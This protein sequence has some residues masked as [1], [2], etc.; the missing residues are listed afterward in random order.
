MV[1]TKRAIVEIAE[2]LIRTKGYHA[3]SYADISTP[4]KIKNSA[5]HYHFPSKEDLGIAVIEK[6]KERFD[7]LLN[8][9]IK[10][11]PTFLLTNFIKVYTQSQK[12]GMICFMGALGPAY[13]SL[14]IRM[15][16][17]LR[18]VANEIRNW[19][20]KLLERGRQSNDFHFE[21]RIEEKADIIISSLMSSLILNEVI[22]KDITKNV[23]SAIMSSIEK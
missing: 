14:P 23:I 20:I 21:E 9:G 3:F 17:H 8:E 10:K 18:A 15:Q 13:K 1:G 6:N 16:V 12:A 11:S 5:I 2:E 19:L 22:K 7:V 4:L